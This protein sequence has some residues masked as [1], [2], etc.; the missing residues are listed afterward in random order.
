MTDNQVR[1]ARGEESRPLIESLSSAFGETAVIVQ[2]AVVFR[3]EQRSVV[4]VL[5]AKK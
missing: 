2:S 4:L 5:Y 1:L 3:V